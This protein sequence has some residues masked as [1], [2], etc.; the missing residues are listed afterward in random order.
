MWIVEEE[1]LRVEKRRNCR[2]RT[3]KSDKRGVT[4]ELFQKRLKKE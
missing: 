4:V 1:G 2:E 3:M